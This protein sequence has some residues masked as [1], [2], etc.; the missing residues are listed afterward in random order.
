MARGLKEPHQRNRCFLLIC[1][2][3]CVWSTNGEFSSITLLPKVFRSN[4]QLTDMASLTSQLAP[5][6][7]FVCLPGK[8][9]YLPGFHTGFA[10]P[11]SSDLPSLRNVYYLFTA[12]WTD[13]AMLTLRLRTEW[14]PH[15]LETP[16]SSCPSGAGTASPG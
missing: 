4:P 6:V 2:C 3:V 14:K 1:L 16:G 8:P 12:H 10:G 13:D 11:K 9:P 7:P 15:L 5:E